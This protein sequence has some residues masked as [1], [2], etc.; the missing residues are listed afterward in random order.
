MRSRKDLQHSRIAVVG[1]R[2]LEDGAPEVLDFVEESA[3]AKAFL[4][5][6]KARGGG[7]IPEDVQGGLAKALSLSWGPDAA[8]RV[9]I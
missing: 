7:D 9:R 2:D 5:N 6:V 8:E 4:E 1:Y 3:T